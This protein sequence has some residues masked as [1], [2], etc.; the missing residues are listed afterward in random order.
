MSSSR[1]WPL[2]LIPVSCVFVTA[3]C[4]VGSTS[5][6]GVSAGTDHGIAVRTSHE[7]AGSH[8]AL[9]GTKVEHGIDLDDNGILDA[10]EPAGQVS[11]LCDSVSPLTT[12]PP[13]AEQCPYGGLI[14]TV[15]GMPELRCFQH[16]VD[17]DGDG[18]FAVDPTSC[19]DGDDWCDSDPANWTASACVACLDNDH[20]GYGEG[21][22][23][24]PDCN[25]S[26]ASSWSWCSAPECKDTSAFSADSFTR[27]VDSDGPSLFYMLG[28]GYGTLKVYDLSKPA[29]PVARGSLA[30]DA[31]S[32]CWYAGS[33]KVAPGGTHAFVYGGGCLGLPVIDITDRANPVPAT[34]VTGPSGG[35]MDIDVCGGMLYMAVQSKG[36]A[37]FDISS[38]G[39]PVFLGE[40]IIDGDPSPQGVTCWTKDSATDDVYLGDRGALGGL[41]VYSFDKPTRTFTPRGTYLVDGASWGGRGWAVSESLLYMT[42]SNSKLALLDVSDKDSIPP[43]ATFE[44]EGNC[45]TDLLVAGNQ[46][47]TTY[48]YSQLGVFDISTPSEPALLMNKSLPSPAAGLSRFAVEGRDYLAYTTLGGNL[49]SVCE[50]TGF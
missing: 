48:Q 13:L 19:A 50:L 43:P 17:S 29:S 7:P 34:R 47:F 15:G 38:P 39:A 35:S 23:R 37:A 24:G 21:C 27:S 5:E 31:S 28:T 20:D 30:L 45:H 46:L 16:C 49:V 33:T 44:G 4:A 12:V 42:W 32:G 11:F 25:D 14:V 22:D 26:L 8:C 3:G 2:R 6:S 10:D 41:R 18:H 9:G 40:S 1:A 36:V